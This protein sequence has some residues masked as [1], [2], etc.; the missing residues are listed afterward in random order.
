MKAFGDWLND[1]THDLQEEERRDEDCLPPIDAPKIT[2][3]GWICTVVDEV[4]AT[5]GWTPELLLVHP[6]TYVFLAHDL[7]AIPSAAIHPYDGMRLHG[8]QVQA[9]H[10]PLQKGKVFAF[11][12]RRP[13]GRMLAVKDPRE[14]A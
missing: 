2:A 9:R 1:L 3:T 12:Q 14:D 13:G 11:Q 4:K 5:E 10:A 6:D 7:A 8:V